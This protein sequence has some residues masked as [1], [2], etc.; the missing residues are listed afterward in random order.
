MKFMDKS[1]GYKGIGRRAR[2]LMIRLWKSE[3]RG[4]SLKAWA[5]KA[6]VGEAAAA[7]LEHKKGQ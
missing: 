1:E 3:G 4:M 6:G 7:W 5:R 2:R